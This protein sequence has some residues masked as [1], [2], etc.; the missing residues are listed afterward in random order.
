MLEM[1]H[2]IAH[3]LDDIELTSG[4][5]KKKKINSIIR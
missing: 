4:W 3:E 2:E 5:L 1:E